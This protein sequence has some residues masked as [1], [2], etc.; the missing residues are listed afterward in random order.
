[1]SQPAY[2]PLPERALLK[3][4][5][6]DVFKF[7]QGIITNDIYGVEELETAV[8]AFMLTPQGKYLFDFII[9]E[10]NSALY[11]D[12]AAAHKD[13]L[14]K[15]LNM[16]KL[17]SAV[18][19]ED[20]SAELKVFAVFGAGQLPQ[21]GGFALKDPRDP[22]LEMRLY[23]PAPPPGLQEQPL[24]IYE[25]RRL[26]LS[27]PDSVL[28]F[29][30]EKSF[31]LHYRGEALNAIDFAKG[32][33][34]G[35]EVTARTKHLGTIRKMLKAYRIEGTAPAAGEE[36][37][38]D[39]SKAGLMRSSGQGLGLVLMQLEFAEAHPQFTANGAEFTAV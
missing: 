34:V 18:T 15:R 38:V 20:T 23:A 31:P 33:Y 25:Q 11:L 16:Y 35:Q 26:S 19:I 28:D 12:C 1:M 2:I 3:L 4:S 7:L 22:G 32:C 37:L 39:G 27:I 8:Y 9:F 14:L 6:T 29:Q 24:G 30:Q 36:L 10:W 21:D 17:R 13:A 5:G